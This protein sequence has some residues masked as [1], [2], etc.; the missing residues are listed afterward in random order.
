[1]LIMYRNNDAENLKLSFESDLKLFA[2]EIAL[3]F[4]TEFSQRITDGLIDSMDIDVR[5]GQEAEKSPAICYSI[6]NDDGIENYKTCILIQLEV[7]TEKIGG[8]QVT[9]PINSYVRKRLSER[10]GLSKLLAEPVAYR[11]LQDF[12]QTT[13][14]QV[15][16]GL[17]SIKCTQPQK[18]WQQ[19]FSAPNQNTVIYQINVK[20]LR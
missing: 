2:T 11:T 20:L 6:L 10:L 18:G 12:T 4:N 9:D 3:E 13:D 19:S 15:N 7:W 1:M 8:M 5:E 17:Y 14:P 16:R